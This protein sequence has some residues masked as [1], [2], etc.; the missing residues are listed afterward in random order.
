MSPWVRGL[1]VT[2]VC[3][4]LIINGKACLV[5][6]LGSGQVLIQCP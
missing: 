5:C 3:S 4:I 6:P 1:A 2:L